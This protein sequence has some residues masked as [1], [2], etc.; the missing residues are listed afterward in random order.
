MSEKAIKTQ[1][2]VLTVFVIFLLDT[3][4]RE[5][6]NSSFILSSRCVGDLLLKPTLLKDLSK[7]ITKSQYLTRVCERKE[8]EGLLHNSAVCLLK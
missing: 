3:R 1:S 2:L 6:T 4:G 8:T 7:I 5:I